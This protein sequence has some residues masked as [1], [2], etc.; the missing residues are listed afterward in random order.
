MFFFIRSWVEIIYWGLLAELAADY[1]ITGGVEG[2]GVGV[3]EG[4]VDDVV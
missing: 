2:V 4:D 3:D 1:G